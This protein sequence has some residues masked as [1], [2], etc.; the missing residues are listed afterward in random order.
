MFPVRE[1]FGSI[2]EEKSDFTIFY[3]AEMMPAGKDL[4]AAPGDATVPHNGAYT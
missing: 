2:D 1:G 3:S 4:R